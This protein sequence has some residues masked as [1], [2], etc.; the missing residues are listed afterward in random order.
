MQTNPITDYRQKLTVLQGELLTHAGI[1]RT[2]F[3]AIVT[4]PSLEACTKLA[5]YI[6][7][8]LKEVGA[9]QGVTANGI[10]VPERLVGNGL[11]IVYNDNN[12][13]N[14]DYILYLDPGYRYVAEET[15]YKAKYV[16]IAPTTVG[17]SIKEIH[18]RY[19]YLQY[20]NEEDVKNLFRPLSSE[21]YI[22]TEQLKVA[23]YT[24][25]EL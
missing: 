16:F 14:E 25:H 3:K 15:I 6:A 18:V 21:Q 8:I 9:I 11:G 23:T 17:T 12:G 1:T 22:I 5:F 7:G 2:P 19:L 24:M 4:G 13:C 20:S 10:N